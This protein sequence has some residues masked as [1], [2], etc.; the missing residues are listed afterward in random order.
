[1]FTIKSRQIE[2]EFAQERNRASGRVREGDLKYI[3][4]TPEPP[5]PPGFIVLQC[6]YV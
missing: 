3:Y 2:I 5:P 1:M 6:V 4:S